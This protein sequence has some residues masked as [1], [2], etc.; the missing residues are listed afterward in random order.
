MFFESLDND[1]RCTAGFAEVGTGGWIVVNGLC[2]WN[3]RIKAFVA[4]ESTQ[5][6]HVFDADVVGEQSVVTDAMKA[7]R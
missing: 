5:A 6:L 2:F 4:E 3:S 7:W 1:H